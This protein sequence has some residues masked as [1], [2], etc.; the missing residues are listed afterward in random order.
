[1]N[2]FRGD[3]EADE[4]GPRPSL[5][6]AVLWRAM[7]SNR[8]GEYTPLEARRWGYVFWDAARL[9]GSGAIELLEREWY[10]PWGLVDPRRLP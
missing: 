9:E 3:G 8:Y 4:D 1:M 6:W 5:R 2:G 7:Y 10:G